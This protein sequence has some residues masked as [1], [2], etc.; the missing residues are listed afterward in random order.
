MTD[1]RLTD[2]TVKIAENKRPFLFNNHDIV[3]ADDPVI[4]A[5]GVS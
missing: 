4:T 1:I 3:Y 2:R 5:C